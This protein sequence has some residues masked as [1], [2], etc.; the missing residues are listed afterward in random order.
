MLTSVEQVIDALGG[1]TAAANLL[2][3]DVSTVS[4][5]KSRG[6]IPSH[7]FL[8]VSEELERRG[9]EFDRHAFSFRGP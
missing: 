5:W 1:T 2:D 6:A 3:L 4:T 7:Q 9:L 8:R